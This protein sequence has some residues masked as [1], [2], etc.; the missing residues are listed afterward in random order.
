MK[1]VSIILSA[2]LSSAAAAP[3]IVWSSAKAESKH[4]SDVI[5][6]HA[7][8]SNL[9]SGSDSSLKSV[10][11]VVG[12]DVHGSEG[13]TGLTSTG[14]LPKISS[15]Y[16]DASSV[17]HYVRGIDS[18][19]TITKDAKDFSDNVVASSLKL[20]QAA[21]DSD[22]SKVIVVK[23]SADADP[24]EI[25]AAVASVIENSKVGSVVLTAIRGLSEVKLERNA[26]ARKT[27]YKM[28]PKEKGR[29]RLEDNAND[30]NN[31]STSTDGIYFVHFTPNIFAGL[32]FMFFFFAVTYVGIGCMGMIAGQDVYVTKYPTIGR[33]V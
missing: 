15:M 5:N 16:A 33:E 25:D 6:S 22:K 31:G 8:V 23:V 12:R 14:K 11:F 18:V 9:V 7:F 29:R 28:Q 17:H 1:L 2:L 27:M 24:S 4:S 26:N 32:L 21:V 3:A 13:L 20:Y 30:D 10:V 19:E